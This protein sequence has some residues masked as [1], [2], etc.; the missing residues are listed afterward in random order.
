ML[1]WGRKALPEYPGHPTH[2]KGQLQGSSRGRSNPVAVL[3]LPAE[4]AAV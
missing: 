1:T 4:A 3:Y 2:P